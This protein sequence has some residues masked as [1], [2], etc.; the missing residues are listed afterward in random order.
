MSAVSPP[1]LGLTVGDPAGIGPEIVL[2]ALAHREVPAAEWIVYGSRAVLDASSS[3]LNLPPL[4]RSGAT[5]VDVGGEVVPPGAVSSEAGRQAAEAVIRAAEDSLKG[6][7]AGLVTAPLNKEAMHDAGYVVSFNTE[8]TDEEPGPN[9][10]R[11]DAE[12][13]EFWVANVGPTIEAAR[14]GIAPA[15]RR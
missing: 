9:T 13:R 11:L 1:R 2:K 6:D 8:A 14:P 3:W 7:L 10:R 4:E 5:L 12:V 15:A